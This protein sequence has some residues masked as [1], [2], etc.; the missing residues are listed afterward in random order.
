MARWILGAL[1]CVAFGLLTVGVG[2]SMP[3]DLVSDQEASM[4][5]GGDCP[6]VTGEDCGSGQS[7]S[8]WGLVW[9][10]EET[11]SVAEYMTGIHTCGGCEA[12]YT[13][14]AWGC[15]PS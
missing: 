7:C 10:D 2:A 5:V 9:A 15:E 14:D 3:H 8:G 11:G 4:V 6:P 12:G 1:L 13:D